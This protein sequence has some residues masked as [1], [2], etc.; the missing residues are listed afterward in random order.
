[1][2]IRN[3]PRYSLYRSAP[4]VQEREALRQQLAAASSDLQAAQGTIMLLK[5]AGAR[6]AQERRQLWE[7]NAELR[8]ELENLEYLD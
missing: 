4:T 3:Y 5:E 1:M 2:A 7:E 8:V 6:M